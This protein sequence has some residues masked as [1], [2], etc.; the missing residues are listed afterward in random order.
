MRFDRSY[1]FLDNLSYSNKI[2][3]A[4]LV[5][6]YLLFTPGRENPVENVSF[7]PDAASYTPMFDLPP[8]YM[9]EHTHNRFSPISKVV[10]MNVD[11]PE[12]E[13]MW[14]YEGVKKL[15]CDALATKRSSVTKEMKK[16]A[17]GTK[18]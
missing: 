15:V 1:Q 3:P 8:L 12:W 2:S 13:H 16:R 11:S 5:G 6:Q 10:G 7:G 14:K 17:E 18:I 4:S 9:D